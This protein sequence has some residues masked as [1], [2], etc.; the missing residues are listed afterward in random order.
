[1]L[2][3]SGY[4]LCRSNL[5]VA[6]PMLLEESSGHGLTQETIGF[7]M[8]LGVLAY[9]LGKLFNGVLTDFLDGR[10]VFLC[11]MIASV[12]C[13]FVFG[14]GTGV[15]V[16]GSAWIANRFVQ[17]MGWP[18]LASVAARWFPASR[19]AVVMGVL[20]MSYLIGDAAARLLL[21]SF[22]ELGV[23][24]RGLFYLSGALLAVI[25][26][27]SWFTLR[28]TPADAGLPEPHDGP[29][30]APGSA[31]EGPHSPWHRLALL[32]GCP[33][34]WLVCLMSC[35]L[36]MIRETFN[37]WTPTYLV[38]VVG[39]KVGGAAFGSLVFPL[40]GGLAACTGGWLSHCCGNRHGRVMLPSL[41]LMVLALAVLSVVPLEGRPTEALLLLAA[42]GMF[43][44]IPYSFCCGVLAIDLGGKRASATATGLVDTAGYAGGIFSGWGIAAVA[45]AYGWPTAF[46]LLAATGLATS[47]VVIIYMLTAAKKKG[48]ANGKGKAMAKF[49][50]TLLNLL[51]KHG[52]ALYGGE[53]VTQ[54]EH[55]LQAALSAEQADAG[56]AL[57]TAA[58]LHDIGHLLPDSHV[59]DGA[60]DVDL[61]HE[62][63]G[64][65]WLADYFPPDVVE[66]I[67]LHV[68]AKRYLCYA[69]A[70]YW[71]NLSPASQASLR[72]Q[73]GPY[74]AE[75]AKAFMGHAH[76]K[77][78]VA[79]R[80]WD[81]AAK[82]PALPT[83][84]VA[85]Y[86]PFLEATLT[87]R[88]P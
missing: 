13:T 37:G 17:S 3:Y 8:S 16:L 12:V 24:W 87:R 5:S 11:G 40:T 56:P 47:V 52:G 70:G 27:G 60:K 74:T 79:L 32:L 55:A 57:V 21:G 77:A 36:T 38:T 69:E 22:V 66:P 46:S 44:T 80:R 48:P 71:Q 45:T 34:L 81:E 54:R 15:F 10:R 63:A 64:A 26:A 20:S 7:M 41:I 82:V 43:M 25:A 2:G 75:Q 51:E 28:S 85:H 30:P 42:V 19:Q 62:E 88:D 31:A 4:Y 18:A 6:A 50:T 35:G 23:G 68:A 53:A 78:A 86:R 9:A 29:T 14:L 84:D 1:L 73:G 59:G 39:M 67:R 58:L 65:V 33:Q 83:P 76:A 49:I 61:Q 72:A